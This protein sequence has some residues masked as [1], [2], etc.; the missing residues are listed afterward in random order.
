MSGCRRIVMGFAVISGDSMRVFAFDA[1]GAGDRDWLEEQGCGGWVVGS[2][3]LYVSG[4][5]REGCSCVSSGVQRKRMGTCRH[6]TGE[7][8]HVSVA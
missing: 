6:I 5:L 7:W 4:G 2:R 1:W 8:W 3:V